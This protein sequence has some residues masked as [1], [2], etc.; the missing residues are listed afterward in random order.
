MKSVSIKQSFL[1]G[2]DLRLDASFHLSVGP[3][4][5]IKLLKSPYPKSTLFD[6]SMNILSG[7][8]FKR[9]FVESSKYG[10]PYL[11][12]SDMMKADIDSGKYISKKYTTQAD[13]L[14]IKKGWILASCSGTLGNPVFTNDD[15]DGRIGTH[16]LIRIVPNEKNTLGG[17]VY[18]YLSS[19]YGYGLLTQS[20]YGGVIKHLE[21]HHIQD[22]PIP[23]F[24]EVKQQEI[25]NLII[26]ASNL[27]AEANKL[28]REAIEM[29]EEK[30]PSIE[31]KT[32][33]KAKIS[34]RIN[35]N[36]RIEATYNSNSIEGL[37]RILNENNI[38]LKSISKISDKV[39]TPGIFKRI[40]TN[41]PDKGVPFLSGSD[42]LNQYPNFQSFL[43][44]K[45]KNI[46]TYII[47]EGWIAIQD[48][49]TIEYLSYIT[50]FL[51]GVSATNNL[52]RV[53]PNEN[54]NKNYYIYCFL[55]T[56]VGQNL[57]KSL[58]YGS[59]QKYIDNHQVSS[60]LVQ[61]FHDIEGEIFRKIEKSMIN[62]SDA[63]FMEKEAIDLV[64]KEIESWQES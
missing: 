43:S 28:L 51:D 18:A 30:L 5:E 9:S 7:N 32:I 4:T 3:L 33:Y 60:F 61:I 64:E 25:H 54:D 23:L 63:C 48:A 13:N 20:S 41:N 50:K 6:E 62:L 55:K 31:F 38:E 42:L 45:T 36:S 49:G 26:E 19:K 56:K 1:E 37:Y 15:F 47:R 21:P 14:L 53:V 40:G 52:V 57:L 34:T 2:A 59:L 35:H 11:T 8:I 46:D 22:L 10:W 58:E 27:R 39:F 12:G 29:M 24:P 17:F 16:D 44:R